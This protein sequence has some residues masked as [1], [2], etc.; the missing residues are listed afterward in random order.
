[1]SGCGKSLQD[2]VENVLVG[3][4]VSVVE[5][6]VFLEVGSILEGLVADVALFD[7]VHVKQCDVVARAHV[8][9]WVE[10]LRIST[11]VAHGRH[12]IH[13]GMHAALRVAV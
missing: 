3:E 11:D 2:S 8:V 1:M 9:K 6:H 10:G 5:H 4:D 13:V 12:S 7:L